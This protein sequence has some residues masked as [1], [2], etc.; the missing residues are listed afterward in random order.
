MIQKWKEAIEETNVD[1]DFYISRQRSEDEIFPWDFIDAGITKEFLL[2][3][4]HNSQAQ[5]VTPNCMTRCSGCGAN[6]FG[7]GICYENKN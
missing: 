5:K 3:E 2:R 4:Y 1:L 6:S 7:G